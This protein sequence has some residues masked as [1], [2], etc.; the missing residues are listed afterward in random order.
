TSLAMMPFNL[1][2]FVTATLVVRIYKRYSPR[3]IGTVSFILTT[4]ALLW[5]AF[6]VTNNWETIP[7]IIGLIVFGIG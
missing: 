2:V 6:V 4:V 5:L 7:T 1:T 3:V